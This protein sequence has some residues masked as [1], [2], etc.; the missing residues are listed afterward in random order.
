MRELAELGL[1]DDLRSA[2][3]EIDELVYLTK[4]GRPIWQE[5]RGLA[6][7]Y[8]WPQVAIHRGRLQM[9]L[10][11]QVRRRLGPD[12]VRFGQRVASVETDDGGVRVQFD[13]AG[14]PVFG[15]V[16]IAAD[17]IHSA[18]RRQFYPA[19][20]MPKWNRVTLWRSTTRVQGLPMGRRMIWAGHSR[21]KFVAYPIAH[22]A[23]TGETLLNWI[24]D[25]K[26]ESGDTPGREDWNRKGDPEVLLSAFA[27]WRWE[28]IDVPAIVRGAGDIYEFPMVDRDP[29]PAWTFGRTTLLGDAAHPMYP[30]GSNGATQGV[31]DARV[32]ALHLAT[33]PDPSTALARYE[34][35]RRQATSR[36]VLM[37]RAQGPDR[38]MDLA[39]DRA[40]SLATDLD[41][42]LPMAERAV[43]A[44]EYKAVAGFDPATLNARA[45][46][47]PKAP[48]PQGGA[49][50]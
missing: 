5:P 26:A 40:P 48:A 45:S 1:L 42:V 14:E 23:A 19:E 33:A 34:A 9:L 13:G 3:V 46:F 39:E 7:G 37:N 29:L 25:L 47:S 8:R 43:I 50:A 21:Q 44:A 30:I 16:L 24:C 12:A 31:I 38:V 10:L 22:D 49:G 35:D 20:G 17:G 18:V 32:I 15:D 41:V 27:D 28:G 11:D 36:I 6:A 4:Y 2:G